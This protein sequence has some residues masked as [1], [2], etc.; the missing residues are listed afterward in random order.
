MLDNITMTLPN[1][2]KN[3]FDRILNKIQSVEIVKKNENVI[4][5]KWLNMMLVYYP[6]SHSLEIKNS[7]HKLFN[8]IFGTGKPDNST[9]FTLSQ[10]NRVADF[11][12]ETFEAEQNDIF[13][14]GRFEFGV[15]IEIDGFNPYNI[16]QRYL[17]Y[18]SVRT[19]PFETIAGR[20][21][22]PKQRCCYLSDYRLKVYR[23]NFLNGLDTRSEKDVMRYEVVT[24][25]LR[26][27]RKISGF[28]KI[29]LRDIVGKQFWE[30]LI[31]YTLITHDKIQKIPL[32]ES[33]IS[34]PD[35]EMITL[36]CSPIHYFDLKRILTEGAL[37][38]D[39]QKQKEIYEKW[40]K[41]ESNIHVQI[42]EIIKQKME[43]LISN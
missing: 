6:N 29:T 23:K 7:I 21:G 16:I 9:D 43:Y 35:L 18:K 32:V 14:Q 17:S 34:K 28:R 22:K 12:A 27:L 30:R 26:M 5:A 20:R 3:T 25:E 39:R 40:N 24:T 36:Y 4:K 38:Q 37:K 41:A 13:I 31:N 15:N 8:V 10:L 1:I 42:R 19:N 33:G 2:S 11:I